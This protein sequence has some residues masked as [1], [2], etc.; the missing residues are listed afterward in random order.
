MSKSNPKNSSINKL[1]LPY[2]VYERHKAVGDL[3]LK[4]ET[5]LDIGGELNHLSQFCHPAKIVVANLTGGDVII[6]KEKLPFAKNSFDVVSSIDVLE[7]IPKEDRQEFVKKLTDIAA[8]RV[9]LSFPIG[10]TGHVKYEKEIQ[11]WLQKIGANVSFLK[12]HIKYGLPTIDEISKISKNQESRIFYSGNLTFN[13]Y[14]FYLYLFDPQ[15]KYLGKLIYFSKLIFNF[16][17]NPIF[18]AFL[19]NRKFSESINRAYLIIDKKN[20]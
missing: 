17:T 16:L 5:V 9:I 1:L 2:D 19:S 6:Q 13:K 4:N 8:K 10:T 14:L 20:R 11:S 15:I 3:I 7:H 18:Y 12:E